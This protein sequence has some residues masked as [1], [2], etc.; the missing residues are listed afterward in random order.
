M[1]SKYRVTKLMVKMLTMMVVNMASDC[2]NVN[3][4][5]FDDNTK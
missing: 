2:N 4:N 3:N 5:A 1:S